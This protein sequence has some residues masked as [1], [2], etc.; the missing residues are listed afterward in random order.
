MRH[1]SQQWGQGHAPEI[2]LAQAGRVTVL[3]GA[4]SVRYGADALGG[5]IMVEQASLPYAQKAY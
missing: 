2:A 4:E 1:K 5:V 3:K